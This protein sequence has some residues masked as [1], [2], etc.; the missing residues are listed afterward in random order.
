ME[1][2]NRRGAQDSCLHSMIEESVRRRPEAAALVE[3]RRALTYAQLDARAE[4]TAHRL[5]ARGV[6]PG[7]IV[8][9]VA[10]RSAETVAALL[11]VLKAGAAYCPL[12]PAYP[13]ERLRFM[14]E[15]SRAAALAAGREDAEKLASPARP[16]FLFEESGGREHARSEP[17]PRAA[18]PADLAYVIYTSG[19][20]GKPKG[21]MVEHGSAANYVRAVMELEAIR[22][23]TRALLFSSMSFDASV[24]ELF[25]CLCA[26]GTMFLRVDMPL[27]GR[28][29]MRSIEELGIERLFL[30]TAYWHELAAE[31]APRGETLPACVRS[32]IVGG[33]AL[34]AES[35]A[36]WRPAAGR[37]RLLNSYGPTEATVS[38]SFH[39]VPADA[40]STGLLPIGRP[41]A[42]AELRVVDAEGRQVPNGMIG[43]LWIGGP[44]VGRGY[45]NRPELTAERFVADSLSGRPGARLYRT[46]DRARRRPDGVFEY[47]G[48]FDDQVKIRGYR[49]ELGEVES[50]LAA[51]PA[52]GTCAVVLR[53][54][55]SGVQR[56]VAYVSPRDGVAAADSELRAFLSEKMPDYM[57]PSV[58]VGLASLP[59]TPAGK[60]DRRAL[61]PPVE[62]STAVE[63]RTASPLEQQIR[64]IWEEVLGISPVGLRDDFFALG[65]NSLLAVRIM[66]QIEKRVGRR[67]PLKALFEGATIER[68]AEKMETKIRD[69]EAAFVRL[70]PQAG[71]DPI[72]FVHPGLGF[73]YCHGLSQAT[74]DRPFYVLLPQDIAGSDPV[75]TTEAMARHHL[76]T[77]RTISP[78]G[79][80]LLGGYCSGT[81]IAY[82]IA[83]QLE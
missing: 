82:E 25:P 8:G 36:Y 41:V 23:G 52:V 47:L 73:R 32:V 81:T 2:T 11:G 50:A 58:F 31:L 80:Y 68:F 9:L 34:R 57:V 38:A 14:L 65:G 13:L 16:T 64:D 27:S 19:S 63:E 76:E 54:E 48:R 49:V 5:R 66:A 70:G 69:K 30:P 46:G 77:I 55:P 39:D 15:D 61:P 21:V 42:G 37:V 75:P 22:P 26:G 72:F 4:E 51:H 56:L 10:R 1:T 79:P 60:V 59:L 7:T 43:E 44:G 35:L 18:G 83:R 6:G 62:R 78:R 71:A 67:P 74:P 29:F 3:G 53:E 20:T 33:E 17:E 45:L 12:D 40:P 28:E 24:F